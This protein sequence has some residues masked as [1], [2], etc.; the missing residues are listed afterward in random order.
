MNSQHVTIKEKNDLT[1]SSRQ[2]SNLGLPER[3]AGALFIFI[4]LSPYFIIFSFFTRL[5]MCASSI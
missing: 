3:L 1:L 2:D 4:Y 5:D